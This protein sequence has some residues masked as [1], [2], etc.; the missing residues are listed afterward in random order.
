MNVK[1]YQAKLVIEGK[2]KVLTRS[3]AKQFPTHSVEARS[4]LAG[5]AKEP[6][7]KVRGDVLGCMSTW[8]YLVEDEE[9]GLAW[10]PAAIYGEK[11]AVA[12]REKGYHEDDPASVPTVIL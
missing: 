9:A 8:Y 7:C 12:M 2:E 4:V 1:I 10:E 3:I 6:I 5:E 11:Y